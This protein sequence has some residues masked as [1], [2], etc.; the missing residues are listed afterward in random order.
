MKAQKIFIINGGQ[1]FGHSG[2]RFN[3]TIFEGSL[4]FFADNDFEIRS[5]DINED[6]DP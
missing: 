5:T 2:G 1:K 6:Y 4:K 3:K